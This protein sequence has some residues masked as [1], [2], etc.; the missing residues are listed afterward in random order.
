MKDIILLTAFFV[1][2]GL[3]SGAI[4]GYA[5]CNIVY[6]PKSN[7]LIGWTKIIGVLTVCAVFLPGRETIVNSFFGLQGYEVN[8]GNWM[9]TVSL[10]FSCWFTF[11]SSRLKKVG[12]R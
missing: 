6:H 1:G 9:I 8:V 7:P 3:I 11:R 4:I 12:A 5:S 10:L 2:Y